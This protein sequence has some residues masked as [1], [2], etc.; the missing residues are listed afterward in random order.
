[1]VQERLGEHGLNELERRYGQ[2]LD[3]K[4]S[5]DV[6]ISDEVKI[7]EIAIELLTDGTVTEQERE[8][9]AGRLHFRNFSR[10]PFGRIIFSVF[11]KSFHLMML[12]AG[13]VAGHVF[14][15]VSFFS[16]DL[17]DRAI[18]VIMEN[19]DYPKEHFRGLFYEWMVFSGLTG[20]VEVEETGP[21]RYEYLMQ[22]VENGE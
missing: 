10:T 20:T 17:G 18:R 4:N 19:S 21:N 13:N 2:K 8:Y 14:S 22:W 5:D 7:L 16:E 11:R 9:E 6:P 15:G 3:I 12:R 1:M